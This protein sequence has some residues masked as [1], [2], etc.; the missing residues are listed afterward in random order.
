MAKKN[1]TGVNTHRAT[2]RGYAKGMLIE[3][4]DFV[5]DGVTISDA[6]MEEVEGSAKRARAVREAQADHPGDPNLEALSK[7][8]LEAMAAERGVNTA[9]L[10]KDDLIVAIRAEREPTI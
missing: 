6:W 2:Q 9:G 7:A 8:A 3:P 10:S 1:E 4:E 5:P